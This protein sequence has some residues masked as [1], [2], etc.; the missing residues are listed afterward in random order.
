MTKQIDD[1]IRSMRAKLAAAEM[2]VDALRMA[3]AEL[4]TADGAAARK[5][6]PA[7]LRTAIK[8]RQDAGTEPEPP[9][10]HKRRGKRG[11]KSAR[12]L[13]LLANG[14]QTF[15]ALAAAL[16]YRPGL[17]NYLQH[18]GLITR[19]D[20]L[21]NGQTEYRIT[22]AGQQ[23]LNDFAVGINGGSIHRAERTPQAAAPP[24]GVLRKSALARVIFRELLDHPRSMPA[25][26][27]PLQAA[28][29]A[30]MGANK[31]S[32]PMAKWKSTGMLK[33][34][35]TTG[36]WRLTAKGKAHLEH[37]DDTAGS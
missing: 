29:H 30:I 27:E 35:P 26:V 34:N 16:G 36:M 28:G 18:A 17:L 15:R 31:I 6:V 19:G 22:D 21:P 14:P 11:G 13:G 3:V 10:S 5:R 20:K 25:L 32:G 24:D 2:L 4:E 7:T 12:V 8:L 33:H 1:V 37:L 23:W 9:R